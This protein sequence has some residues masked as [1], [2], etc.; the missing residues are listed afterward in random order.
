MVFNVWKGVGCF[1]KGGAL[2]G[3]GL[4]VPRR[5]GSVHPFR[6][7][8]LPTTCSDLLTSPVFH[9]MINVIVPRVPTRTLN[10]VVRNY[11]AYRRFRCAFVHPLLSKIVGGYARKLAGSFDRLRLSGRGRGCACVSGR[12]SVIL[13]SNLLSVIL[14]I[15]GK[16]SAIRVTVNS[17]LLVCP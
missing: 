4:V 10:P 9:T 16:F 2:W 5:F 15:R 7:R 13:S 1:Y 17:G 3:Q 11:G 6:P 14:F 8:R 12:H